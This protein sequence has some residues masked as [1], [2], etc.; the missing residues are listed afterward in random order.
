MLHY[1]KTVSGKVVAHS[2]AFRVVLYKYIAG[3]SSVPLNAKG[4]TPIGSTCV[5]HTSPHSAAAVR[6]IGKKV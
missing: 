1:M 5:A 6:D 4:P 2:F 3:G